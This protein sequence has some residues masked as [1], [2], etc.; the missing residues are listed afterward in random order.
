MSYDLQAHT[1]NMLTE[2]LMQAGMPLHRAT[3]QARQTMRMLQHPTPCVDREALERPLHPEDRA[4]LLNRAVPMPAVAAY[5]ARQG[6]TDAAD[7]NRRAPLY[8]ALNDVAS[9]A[10]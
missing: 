8:A 3:H 2:A 6:D 7:L 5:D 9:A 4:Y 10:D 1:E